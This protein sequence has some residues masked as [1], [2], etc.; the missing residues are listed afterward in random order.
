MKRVVSVVILLIIVIL[1]IEFVVT[2]LTKTYTVN[3]KIYVDKEEFKITEKYLKNNGDTYDLEIVNGNYSFY[4]S[5][6]N[7]FN[8]QKKIVEDVLMFKNGSDLCIY[9]V[10]KNKVASYI[11]CSSNGNLFSKYTYSDQGFINNINNTLNEKGIKYEVVNSDKVTKFG[12][13]DVYSNNIKNNDKIVM[14]QYKGIY[15]VSKDSNKSIV[16]LPFDKYENK[17]GYLVGKYY[18]IPEY[19]NSNV[20]EFSKVRVVNVDTLRESS[21]DLGYILSSNTYVNGVVDNKLYYTDPSNLIQIEYNPKNDKVELVGDVDKGGTLYDG[22]WKDAN[23]YDFASK[24]ILFRNVNG[25][26]TSYKD[27]KEGSASYYYYTNDGSIYQV[28]KNHLDKP[29]LVY[30]ANGLNNFNVV[31]SDI[32]YVINN[33]LYNFNINNGVTKILVNNDLI[34]N[35]YNRVSV[36]R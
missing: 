33:T 16:V 12:N 30:R 3:Y 2:K 32:Y 35:T 31:G 5:I 23:I 13:T 18:V 19:T 8:K 15:V 7:V 4:Y 1:G 22:E 36:Y 27:I 6:D 9:P 21:V 34:Y 24:E 17:V 14:W 11:E 25:I 29:I 28:L 26:N 10:L 20:L